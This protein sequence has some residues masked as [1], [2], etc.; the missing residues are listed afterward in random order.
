MTA[1]ELY[2]RAINKKNPARVPCI[3]PGGM[4]NMISG[5]IQDRADT[6]WPEAHSDAAKMAK[7]ASCPYELG[8]LDNIG[9]PF[10]MTVE[11]EA[12][13]AAVDMGSKLVEP[14]VS[15]YAMDSVSE[16]KKLPALDPEKGRAKVVLDS[17]GII[18]KTHPQAVVMGNL[19]GPISL[20]TSLMDAESFYKELR[21]KPADAGD[22]LS[23]LSEQ[24]VSFGKAQIEAGADFI[25]IADPSGTGEILGPVLFERFALPYINHIASELRPLCSGVTVHICG[26][27]QPIY[28]FIE[29]IESDVI[30]VDSVVP[31]TQLREHSGGKAIM[32]NVSTVALAGSSETVVRSNAR[33]CLENRVNILAPACGL[34][35]S[36]SISNLSVLMESSKEASNV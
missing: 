17:L 22:F 5:E 11:A 14:I 2:I 8:I 26:R 36:T 7:L 20:A 29:S 32:G 10:C 23:F 6:Y 9:V 15:A 21:K 13:G 24:L 30:S 35:T 34:G 28:R 4:M 12:L 31:L 3:C 33:H 16:W 1:K 18:K 25:T 27:L 19:T